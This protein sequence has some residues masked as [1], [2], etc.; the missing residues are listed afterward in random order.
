MSKAQARLACHHCGA[1][2]RRVPLEINECAVCV[3]CDTV[4]ETKGS[5][6]AGAWI[7]IVVTAMVTFVLANAYPVGTLIVQGTAQSATF[8]DAVRVTWDAGYPEVALMTAAAGFVFPIVHLCLLLWVLGPLATNRVPIFFETAVT[9]IDKLKPWCMIP[10]F[11]LGAL[12]SIVK[13]VDLATLHIGIGLFA[14]LVTAVLITG[15][16]RLDSEKLRQMAHDAQLAVPEAV[17]AKPPSPAL[18][19]R[20]W[21]LLITAVILYIPANTL[22]IMS[23]H[24]ING[25]SGHTIL[26]GVIELWQM[27]SWDIALVVFIASVFVPFLKLFSLGALVWLTQQRSDRNLKFRTK[28]YGM[29]EFIGQWSMLDVFVVI[30][31][32]ALGKFGS[33]LDIT[34]GPGAVAFGAVVVMTMIAAMGFDPRLAWRLAGH[35]RHTPSAQ[36]S[37]Q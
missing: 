3:R 29:V 22:P 27:G 16:S 17:L 31:L 18:L 25:S 8:L 32:S 1:L 19:N 37:G 13:L 15:L 34:P 28:T 6:T 12:V 10:V 4:L 2:F 30:L 7:A 23:I 35:R 21:A 24:A 26:G 9:L 20:T 14:T 33:L 36:G 5:F 11:L